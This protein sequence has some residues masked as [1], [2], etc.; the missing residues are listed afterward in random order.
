MSK[1]RPA[2]F[3]GIRTNTTSHRIPRWSVEGA[4]MSE[5][6]SAP[7][8]WQEPALRSV[9][10]VSRASVETPK[11]A[12]RTEQPFK[13]HPDQPFTLRPGYGTSA[14]RRRTM[15]RFGP[16]EPRGIRRPSIG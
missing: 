4:R 10:L 11:S 7:K 1:F 8:M 14:S 2:R 3:K 12:T 13:G 15:G 9:H 5:L 16:C 6:H